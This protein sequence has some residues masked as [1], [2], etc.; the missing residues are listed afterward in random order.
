MALFE[1]TVVVAVGT[2]VV[3]VVVIV[4]FVVA[5]NVAVVGLF[6]YAWIRYSQGRY[7][8]FKNTQRH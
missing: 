7:W 4:V 8:A 1:A 5:I 6:K 3:V 2:G